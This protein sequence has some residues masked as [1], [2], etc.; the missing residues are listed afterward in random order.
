MDKY[1]K[2]AVVGQ[3]TFGSVFKARIKE[4]RRSCA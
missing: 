4:V 1:E 3:G 2:L